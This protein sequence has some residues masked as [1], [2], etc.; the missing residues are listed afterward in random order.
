[1][2]DTLIDDVKGVGRDG[3]AVLAGEE[4]EAMERIHADIFLHLDEFAEDAAHRPNIDGFAVSLLQKDYL[5]GSVPSCSDSQCQFREGVVQG[6]YSFGLGGMRNGGF[7]YWLL[8]LY[9][10]GVRPCEAFLFG[11]SFFSWLLFLYFL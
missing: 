8:N 3:V 10:F 7:S 1:M 9:F 11:L 5:R 6:L 4:R 2:G